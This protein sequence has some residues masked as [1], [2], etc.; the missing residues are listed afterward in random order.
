MSQN[1]QEQQQEP[2]PIASPQSHEAEP[3]PIGHI[4]QV[5]VALGI[6]LTGFL[7][8]FLPDELRIGPSWTLIVIEVILLLPLWQFWITG[9]AL[10]HIA[11]RRLSLV[12]LALVTIALSISVILLII[13]ISSFTRGFQLL[14]SASLLWLSNVAVFAL[15]YWNTDGGWS[16]QNAMKPIIRLLISFFH[17]RP[18]IWR[19]RHNFLITSLSPLLGAT[20]FSPTD[21]LPLTRIAKLLMMI[22]G[23]LSFT[24]VAVLLSR[25]ANIL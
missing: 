11:A 3:S 23:L 19:G 21:T 9:H 7:Y 2:D 14:R 12:M 24:I 25:V 18:T 15:W 8:F 5:A 20:A 16:T 13:H 4:P 6:L 22:E 17:S 1:I 10:P